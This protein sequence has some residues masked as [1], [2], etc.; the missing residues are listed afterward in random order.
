MTKK[1]FMA[2]LLGAAAGA[3][4]MYGSS[5]WKTRMKENE[6]KQVSVSSFE[7]EVGDQAS[8]LGEDLDVENEK[9]E[10]A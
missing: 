9:K 7:E 2:A 6:E 1:T 4:A 10:E 3:G 5:K 8:A